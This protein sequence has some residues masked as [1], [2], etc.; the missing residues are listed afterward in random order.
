MASWHPLL[1]P[2]RSLH[3]RGRA[4]EGKVFTGDKKRKGLGDRRRRRRGREM[5]GLRGR[6]EEEEGKICSCTNTEL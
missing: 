1:A 6:R 3:L 5:E 4:V 2:H